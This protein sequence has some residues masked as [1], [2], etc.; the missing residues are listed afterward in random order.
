MM[1][2]RAVC[3][4]VQCAPVKFQYVVFPI[5]CFQ[6]DALRILRNILQNFADRQTL[7]LPSNRR[8]I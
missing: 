1:Q 8:N 3:S 6:L 7:L 2:P 5:F 4:M